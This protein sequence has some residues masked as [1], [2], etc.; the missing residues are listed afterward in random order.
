M[1][2][3]LS[4]TPGT[5]KTKVAR[6]LSKKLGWE[7][8]ELNEMA[9]KKNLYMGY[10]KKRKCSIVDINAISRELDDLRG[11]FIMESHYAHE[12]PADI[13]IILRINPGELRKRLEKRGWPNEK[14]EENIEAEI[15]EVCKN[16]AIG[17]IIYEIETTGKTIEDVADLVMNIIRQVKH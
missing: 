17:K 10:D 2:I 4:G 7:L 6:L 9:R 8:I 12:M 11:D 5:G 15:M 14:I 13:V 1:K 16:D 3:A